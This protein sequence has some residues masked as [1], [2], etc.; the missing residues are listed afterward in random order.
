MIEDTGL[1]DLCNLANSRNEILEKTAQLFKEDFSDVE[2]QKRSKKLE[3]FNP[4]KSAKK[5]IGVI[6]KQ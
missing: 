2:L 6:F 1:E 3:S 4:N 5:I